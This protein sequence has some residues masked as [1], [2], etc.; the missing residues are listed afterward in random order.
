VVP[1]SLALVDLPDFAGNGEIRVEDLSYGDRAS[2]AV[3]PF[4]DDAG[5]GVLVIW[6]EEESGV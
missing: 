6:V 3:I 1:G 5:N 4:E 2:A